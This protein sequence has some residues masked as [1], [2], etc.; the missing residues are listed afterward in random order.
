MSSEEVIQ[1]LNNNPHIM[2][3]WI[4]SKKREVF[5]RSGKW[6]IKKIYG[7]NGELEKVEIYK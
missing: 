4:K 1:L 5:S 7:I 3:Y 2:G 6:I